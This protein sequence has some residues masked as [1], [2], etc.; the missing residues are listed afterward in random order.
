M[1]EPLISVIVPIY[2]VEEYLN[3]CVE[4]LVNQTYKNLE[5]ILVDD[6]SPD[7][8]PQM[9]D[10][11]AKK[12]SRIKVVHKKNGGLSD[13]R[14]A[15]LRIAT[16]EYI[17]FVD[18]DDWIERCYIEALYRAAADNDAELS[19]CDVRFVPDGE[20]PESVNCSDDLPKV[21]N[22]EEALSQL[23]KGEGFRAV[24]WNKLYSREIL[25]NEF[26][27]VGKYHEDEF[28]TYRI[29]DKC[30]KLSYVNIPLYNYRQREGSIMQ[31][32]NDKH[33]DA[34]DAGAERLVFL[35]ERYPALFV[36]DYV[37]FCTA[38]V[39]YYNAAVKKQFFDTKRIKKRVINAR[40]K[41]KISLH[42]FFKQSLKQKMIILV[43][44]YPL[45]GIFCR[46]K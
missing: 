26:F 2:N 19:A 8:C 17:A 31:A 25:E 46:I 6:G 40:R 38:C 16:G 15:G 9:C 29:I 14:N 34:L 22:A 12:D 13:A 7:N 43:S 5:I 32:K 37:T 1:S 21:F 44:C 33:L 20:E 23:I 42:D 4:S 18:S 36:A 35:K 24:A 30:E 39:G 41:A 10:D 27:E 3:R 11:W 28:F 45:I